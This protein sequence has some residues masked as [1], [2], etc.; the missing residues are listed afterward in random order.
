MALSSSQ[1]QEEFEENLRKVIEIYK[2]INAEIGKVQKS[3]KTLDLEY[4]EYAKEAIEI[5]V[6]S[7]EEDE[8]WK[9]IP[10]K[11]KE[12]VL[13]MLISGDSFYR[14]LELIYLSREYLEI[15]RKYENEVRNK[16]R[17]AIK[18][19]K[20]SY[21]RRLLPDWIE[22]YEKL[23]LDLRELSEEVKGRIRTDVKKYEEWRLEEPR[24]PY[25]E[26]VEEARI[27]ISDEFGEF[28]KR[29]E[30]LNVKYYFAKGLI[31]DFFL[32]GLDYFPEDVRIE[33][34]E[35]LVKLLVEHGDIYLLTTLQKELSEVED[36]ERY[37]SIL[38]QYLPH[39]AERF[40]NLLERGYII[41][42]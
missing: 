41:I 26:V 30:S 5:F 33:I 36:G 42:F 11:M 28:I 24:H 19:E 6:E 4:L 27:K 8:K 13:H 16:I 20:Y 29:G 9:D 40:V 18:K 17:E 12:E 34:F 31:R 15:L 1:G 14:I 22:L 37:S 23:E 3:D 2:K 21:I 32:E 35:E 10:S 38:Q 39:A 7:G 25:E